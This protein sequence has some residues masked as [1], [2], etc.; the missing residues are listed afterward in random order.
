MIDRH[1]DVLALGGVT[2]GA[3]TG[4]SV[5]QRGP[6]VPVVEQFRPR[7]RPYGADLSSSSFARTVA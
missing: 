6:P 1:T 3:A 2:H 4:W 7:P 5:A